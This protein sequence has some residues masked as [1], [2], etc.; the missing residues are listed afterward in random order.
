LPPKRYKPG[1][2]KIAAITAA[3]SPNCAKQMDLSTLSPRSH[4]LFPARPPHF[5]IG[6]PATAPTVL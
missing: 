3:S 5:F 1:T 2:R 6:S 4:H